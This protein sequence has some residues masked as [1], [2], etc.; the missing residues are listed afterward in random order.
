M[1]KQSQKKKER[2]ETRIVQTGRNPLSS[3]RRYADGRT[4][5][6]A[7]LDASD[8]VARIKTFNWRDSF[9]RLGALAS[10]VFH[11]VAGPGSESVQKWAREQV[12]KM[13]GSGPFIPRAHAWARSSDDASIVHEEAIDFLQH[14]VLMY[15]LE[16][17]DAPTDVELVLWLIGAGEFLGE[18]EEDSGGD[19]THRLIA[20]IARV[21]R[22]NHHED[23]LNLVVR[24]RELFGAPPFVGALSKPET[25]TA[26]QQAAFG[27]PF[28]QHFETRVLPL[29]GETHRWG[30]D[31]QLPVV[32]PDVWVKNLGED[33]PPI[34]KWVFAQARSR[35]EL[36][37]L[38]RKRMRS[39]GLL[40][41][42]PTALLRNPIVRLSDE[43][44]AIASP[45][46]WVD[47]LKMGV[48]A[49]FLDGTKKV[50]G[51]KGEEWFPAFGYMFE[52]WLRKVA[53]WAV[54]DK[55]QGKLVLP[56]YPGSE[57]EVD[58]VIVL[59]GKTTLLFSAK[60]R[61]VEESVARHATSP[62][63][64]M[65]WYEKFL[66]AEGDDEHRGGAVRQ[67]DSRINRIRAG[68]YKDFPT[69][70]QI[71][72]VLV[73][74][75]SLCEEFLLYEWIQER[76][77]ALGLL[78][79][80]NVA[81]LAIAHVDD[82]ERLMARASRGLSLRSFFN[83]REFTWKSRSIHVQL[84]VHDHDDRLPQIVEAF[85]SLMNASSRRL[86]GRAL[87][88]PDGKVP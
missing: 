65:E 40:P 60:A 50:L 75:D 47:H 74:Y 69:D 11:S 31:K 78:Q 48:W 30:R 2:R 25:W 62:K 35:E 8:L 33:G 7:P 71:V 70:H 52:E 77:K 38:T 9:V 56:A 54:S 15:G 83:D 36:V 34:S 72:P 55:F 29:F 82:F 5:F 41:R 67:F 81:Q 18:W 85:E 86:T 88:E 61:V 76:C 53:R 49:G 79:Q 28:E 12:L 13:T 22:F 80:D 43:R 23:P 46:K 27:Q 73:T 51:K 21:S 87:T 57:D 39:D 1:G 32:V 66:F 10:D 37:A 24:I 17:G 16:E 63:A 59:E 19:E 4:V 64:V 42:A 58:D 26:I 3:A 84:G 44:V 6:G 45:Y 68:A 20:E 14:V